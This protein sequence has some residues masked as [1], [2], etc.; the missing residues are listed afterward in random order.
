MS[1]LVLHWT[2]SLYPSVLFSPSLTLLFSVT[3]LPRI[4]T[5]SSLVVR[6]CCSCKHLLTKSILTCTYRFALKIRTDIEP[7]Y[8]VF[9]SAEQQRL[10]EMG[11]TEE[12]DRAEMWNVEE[13]ER[14][15]EEEE[16][17]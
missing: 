5:Y 4:I 1:R 15:K 17:R 6:V 11:V 7:Y 9:Y 3:H 12:Q 8:S 2:P 16:Y 13:I 10:S 14:E